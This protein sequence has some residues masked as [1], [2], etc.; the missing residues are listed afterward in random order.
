MKKELLIASALTASFGLAGVAEAATASWS[1]SSKNG[2][3]GSNLD[4]SATGDST[5][6]ASQQHNLSFSVE[7][8]TDAGMKISTGFTVVNEAA[9]SHNGSG[10]TLTFTDG[11]TL[12][13][14]EAGNVYGGALASI[15]GASGEQSVSASSLNHAPTDLDWADTSDA[16]GFD[17]GSAADFAGIEGLTV[18]VSAA[19]GDDGDSTST[20]TAE[21]S[22][23][24]GATL[25][26]TAGDSTVTIG[27]GMINADSSSVGATNDKANSVAVSASAVT[28]DLTVG[29]GFS[30]GSSLYDSTTD[31]G[32][33]QIDGASIVKAGASYVSGDMTFAVGYYDG[34]G[35]DSLSTNVDGASVDSVSALSASASYTVA[36]GVTAILGYT[37]VST[38]NEGSENSGNSGSSWYVGA[39]ISF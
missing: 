18:G 30:S 23:S 6:S 13:L 1:G 16:V 39:S 11:S 24:I 8:T 31:V 38:N 12:D 36:S 17:W 21:T 7:E 34:E 4:S 22:Y 20:A 5:Y 35:K 9:A 28:G 2:V 10:L 26:T 27:G 3:S 29:V 19:F 33:G 32:A 37:D 25:V 15:P 14:V